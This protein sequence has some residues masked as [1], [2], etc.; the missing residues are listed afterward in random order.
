MVQYQNA[1]EEELARAR[2]ETAKYVDTLRAKPRNRPSGSMSD[3]KETRRGKESAPQ[4]AR[5]KKA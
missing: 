5:R 1:F 4:Q 2:A 3:S